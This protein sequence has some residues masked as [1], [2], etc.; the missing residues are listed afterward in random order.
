MNTKLSKGNSF[1]LEKLK[2]N[3]ENDMFI[4]SD[5]YHEFDMKKMSFLEDTDK[6][7]EYDQRILC[8]NNFHWGQLKLFVSE[9]YVMTYILK[10]SDVK[11]ILYIGAAPGGHL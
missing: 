2:I 3:I 7:R 5:E 10:D 1:S 9:F 4:S 11:D 6:E 8:K